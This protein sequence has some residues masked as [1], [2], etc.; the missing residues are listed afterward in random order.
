M[1]AAS[2]PSAA[3]D[4][5]LAVYLE[6]LAADERVL[7]VGDPSS[8]AARRLATVARSVDVV[9]PNGDGSR[10]SRRGGRVRVR[11]WPRAEDEGRWHVVVVPDLPSSGLGDPEGVAELRRWLRRDGVLAVGSAASGER[12]GP[13]YGDFYDL[14]EPHFDIIRMVGQAPM[15]GFA[16]V[17]FDPPEGE[18]R[19]T[20]DGSL[21]GAP[22]VGRY[23]ALCSDADVDVDA[24]AVIQVPSRAGREDDADEEEVVQPAVDRAAL[25]AANLH[26]EELERELEEVRRR[27]LR[28]ARAQEEAEARVAQLERDNRRLADDLEELREAPGPA[29]VGADEYAR[30]EASLRNRGR[31]LADLRAELERRATLVRDLVEEL[32]EARDAAAAPRAAARPVAGGDGA[33]DRRLLEAQERAAEAEAEGARLRFALDELEG[34]LA[35]A[36]GRS[37]EDVAD[38]HRTEAALRGTVRGLNARL[39]EVL[40]LHQLAQARL[41]LAEDDRQTLEATNQALRREMAELRDQMELQ[42]SRAQAMERDA[43]GANAQLIRDIERVAAEKEGKLIGAL[44]NAQAEVETAR[45][46]REVALEEKAAVLKALEDL[47]QLLEGVRV[48]YEMRVGELR[49]ENEALAGEGER[50][51]VRVG[52][53]AA[54]LASLESEAEGLRGEVAGLRLR[55]ED[56]EAAVEALSS[57]RVTSGSGVP[58]LVA[59]AGEGQAP[60]APAPAGQ[61]ADGR[62]DLVA[63]LQRALSD[64]RARQLELEQEVTRLRSEGP[65]PG[66]APATPR[67]A[68]GALQETRRLLARLVAELP[69]S[70][71]G[72]GSSEVGALRKRLFELDG[73]AADRELMFRSL[74]AQLQERDDRIRALERLREVAG[75]GGEDADQLRRRLLEMEERVARLSD[76]LENE[77]EARRR[78]GRDGPDAR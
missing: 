53:L 66:D 30:L 58:R 22:E 17:D 36:E 78:A 47:E 42:L 69:D 3:A 7:Y 33:E 31:E 39:G 29:E 55:L 68:Q 11:G 64:Q 24:Y 37:A 25:D 77:R 19:V 61:G 40:E 59:T 38:Y 56:R 76:E 70:L 20:F 41:T 54:R 52:E 16:V 14:V 2:I 57:R 50:A 21:G 46:A 26:A 51:R 34:R 4:E 72:S 60:A 62:D 15:T 23:V 5:V 28:T 65:D 49:A 12:A 67:E 13:S 48:G 71:Y 1:S 10:S 8:P 74:T 73:L 45:R 44:R 63:R 27:A 75:P 6:D 35:V 43:G 9:S 32:R 18:H